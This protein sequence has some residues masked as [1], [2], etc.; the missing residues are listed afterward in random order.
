MANFRPPSFNCCLFDLRA[1]AF[2]RTGK[3]RRVRGGLERAGRWEGAFGGLGSGLERVGVKKNQA[4][5]SG[6]GVP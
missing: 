1:E 6:E 4:S 5:P 2:D 3:P